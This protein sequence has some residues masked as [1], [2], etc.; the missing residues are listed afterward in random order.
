MGDAILNS[1]NYRVHSGV[2][3]MRIRV[4]DRY[5]YISFDGMHERARHQEGSKQK[6]TLALVLARV[7]DCADQNIELILELR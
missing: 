1:S 5:K 3:R 2:Q 4:T 7:T 6:Y